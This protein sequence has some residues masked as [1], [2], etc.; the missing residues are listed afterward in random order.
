MY[1]HPAITKRPALK[2]CATRHSL[3]TPATI[4][5]AVVAHTTTTDYP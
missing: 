5:T 4:A 1:Q 3:N 2:P